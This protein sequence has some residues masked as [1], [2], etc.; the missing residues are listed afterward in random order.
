MDA[1]V[2][3]SYKCVEQRFSC[4]EK[5]IYLKTI[6]RDHYLLKIVCLVKNRLM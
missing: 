6:E 5:S 4:N 1:W 2:G 3:I